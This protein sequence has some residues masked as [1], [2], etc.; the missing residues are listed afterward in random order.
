MA[1]YVSFATKR[2][3]HEQAH[4]FNSSHLTLALAINM[5]VRALSGADFETLLYRTQLHNDNARIRLA[6]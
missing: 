2:E 6:L 5:K 4:S 1:G 3:M